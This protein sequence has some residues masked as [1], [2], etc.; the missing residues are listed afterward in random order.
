MENA[1]K[2]DT[3]EGKWRGTTYANYTFY[4][5][6]TGKANSVT[7]LL[8]REKKG[9]KTKKIEQHKSSQNGMTPGS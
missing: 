9:E 8:S 3:S 4:G 2:A 6:Q 5:T 7:T 1:I